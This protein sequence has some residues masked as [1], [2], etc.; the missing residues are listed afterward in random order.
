[1]VFYSLSYD[2]I[3][4]SEQIIPNEDEE[5][6]AMQFLCLAGYFVIHLTSCDTLLTRTFY[7]FEVLF[8]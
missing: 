6:L 4:K 1:M 2:C 3:I 5:T 8:G 7:S